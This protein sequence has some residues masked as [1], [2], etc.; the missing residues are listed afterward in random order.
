MTPRRDSEICG[1]LAR[2]ARGRSG[3]AEQGSGNWER[4]QRERQHRGAP[5][6]SGSQ[7]Q[8]PM[9]AGWACVQ[10]STRLGG[11]CWSRDAGHVRED[12]TAPTLTETAV[13]NELEPLGD[14]PRGSFELPPIYALGDAQ[15][16]LD[17]LRRAAEEE[18]QLDHGLLTLGELGDDLADPR[19]IKPRRQPLAEIS[20]WIGGLQP[21]SLIIKR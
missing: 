10:V 9:A 16:T 13:A 19:V 18:T 1:A 15:V 14:V 6:G 2:T 7:L 5:P 21:E 8:R 17:L 20:L 4:G 3:A 12:Q 11:S